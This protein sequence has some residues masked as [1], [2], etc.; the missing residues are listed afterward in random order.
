MSLYELLKEILEEDL[1]EEEKVDLS[2][3]DVIDIGEVVE[4]YARKQI[5]D[6]GYDK[7]KDYIDKNKDDPEV[8]EY[9]KITTDEID[10]GDVSYDDDKKV[11]GQQKLTY[12]LIKR[13]HEK[14]SKIDY[15]P[16]WAKL[17]G[18]DEEL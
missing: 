17:E 1:D 12:R 10:T 8:K 5:T 16:T 13:L 6:D 7:L 4:K 11:M 14:L 15:D 3:A 9:V 18:I 2:S